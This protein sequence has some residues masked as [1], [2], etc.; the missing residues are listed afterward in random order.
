M[1]DSNRNPKNLRSL[2]T[3]GGTALTE[4]EHGTLGKTA[5]MCLWYQL[6]KYRSQAVEMK[7]ALSYFALGELEEKPSPLPNTVLLRTPRRI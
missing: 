2:I 5:K 3:A 4:Q 1:A 7:L 6:G